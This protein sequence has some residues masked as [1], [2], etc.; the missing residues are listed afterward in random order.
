MEF[1]MKALKIMLCKLVSK[2]LTVDFSELISVLKEKFNIVLTES[3]VL[4]VVRVEKPLVRE[5]STNGRPSK[6]LKDDEINGK[7]LTDMFYD[8]SRWLTSRASLSFLKDLILPDGNDINEK[9]YFDLQINNHKQIK[10]FKDGLIKVP[11]LMKENNLD[12]GKLYV[13]MF[14]LRL[15][16]Q[17]KSELSAT[18]IESGNVDFEL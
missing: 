18:V 13:Y 9:R 4:V 3:Q 14:N 15:K 10:V 12:T 16:I 6:Y 17:D 5:L 8:V 7:K 1:R 11:C 2:V